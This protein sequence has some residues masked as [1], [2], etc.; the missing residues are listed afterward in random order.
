VRFKVAPHVYQVVPDSIIS[1]YL[2]HSFAAA[3]SDTIPT[4]IASAIAS[5]LIIS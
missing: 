4:T 5:N 1:H 3:I 2:M